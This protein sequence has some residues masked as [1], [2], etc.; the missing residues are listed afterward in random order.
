MA[1][2]WE[3]TAILER[4]AIAGRSA[5]AHNCWVIPC[6]VIPQK[7][8]LQTTKQRRVQR[9]LLL[10]QL[11][12]LPLAGCRRGGW[13]KGYFADSTECLAT[14]W[15]DRL[16]LCRDQLAT[17]RASSSALRYFGTRTA[18]PCL[19][20]DHNS[21]SPPLL[22]A[23]LRDLVSRQSASWAAKPASSKADSARAERHCDRGFALR[24]PDGLGPARAQ[25]QRR[26][27]QKESTTW[28]EIHR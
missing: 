22:R 27:F 3:R 5:G 9:V 19:R 1:R 2:I 24:G 26:H 17:G 25:A 15:P 11:T 20:F 14:R 4:A 7:I 6:W 8:P 18:C 23:S 28:Q 16:A 21:C 12:L 13:S 10:P